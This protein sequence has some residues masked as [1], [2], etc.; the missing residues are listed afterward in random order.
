MSD[1][2]LLRS[3]RLYEKDLK[4]GQFGLTLAA[5]LLFGKDETIMSAL[6]H[7]RTDAIYRIKDL[8][9]YD[10]RDDI[11]TNLIDSYYR[12]IAFCNKHLD[13]RFYLDGI[14]RKDLRNLIAR[15][16]CSNL[17]IHREFSNP[18]VS[19]LIIEK[20]FIKTE[21]ANKCRRLGKINPNNYEPYPKNPKI[22]DVF[23]QM[24]LVEE[25]GSGVRNLMK[26]TKIYSGGTPKFDEEDI[27]TAIV[28]INYKDDT[29]NDTL[30]DTTNDTLKL[31]ENNKKVL[32]EI[33]ANNS[34]TREE[35]KIK[36]GL[37]DRTISRNIKELQN[38]QIIKREGSKKAGY[39][40]ILI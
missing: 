12:L 28:P 1:E 6:P 14:Q 40:K 13:D 26:Y 34:I 7:H 30:T 16:I 15:E 36:I 32:K 21:N 27:F 25:L 19:K 17:I 39:W 10:D 4:T 29:I 18:F 22:A 2:E 35:L 37:S 20:D 9:R 3:A 24:G 38:K 33:K 31:S 11:R 23:R 8:D 5:I